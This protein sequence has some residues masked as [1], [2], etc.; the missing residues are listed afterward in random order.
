MNDIGNVKSAG[1]VFAILRHFD[2]ERRPRRAAELARATGMPLSSCIALLATMVDQCV[3]RYDDT[4]RCYAPTLELR[5]L[6]DWLC[7]HNPLETRAIYFARRLY[8]ELGAPTAVT[9]RA[10]LYLEW[11][12]TLRVPKLSPGQVRPLCKTINGVASLS[13]LRDPEIEQI[14]AAHN[15]CFGRQHLVDRAAILARAHAAKGRGYASGIASI[16][17]G[18]AAICFVMEDE[19]AGE[20]VLL[21][22][23]V[24]AVD[25]KDR[26]RRIVNTV[27]RMI[28]ELA[29]KPS[30]CA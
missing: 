17:P 21:T 16:A 4:T 11:I 18:L 13:H 23:Q 6:T 10:G 9:R 5:R 22:V 2:E 30:L 7:D 14:V 26:E 27:S 28:P 25:L 24:P 3:L 8:R 15:E 19:A 12:Y 29:L 1:R 20:E